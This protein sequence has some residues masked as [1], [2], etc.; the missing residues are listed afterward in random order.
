MLLYYIGGVDFLEVNELLMF[1][2]S[3]APRVCSTIVILSDDILEEI[4]FFNITLSSPLEDNALIFADPD[5]TVTIIDT[6]SKHT[7]I[8]LI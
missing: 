8:T 2:P 6:S 3:V 7:I 5:A 4:E 1:E